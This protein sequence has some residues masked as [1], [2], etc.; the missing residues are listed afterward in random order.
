MLTNHSKIA[1]SQSLM[2]SQV[3]SG[4]DVFGP[5]GVEVSLIPSGSEDEDSRILYVYTVREGR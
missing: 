4:D 2:W 1:S 5:E 3:T